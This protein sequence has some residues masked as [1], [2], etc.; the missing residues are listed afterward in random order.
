MDFA[1][2]MVFQSQGDNQQQGPR[3]EYVHYQQN[4]FQSIMESI[5]IGNSS[6]RCVVI[7]GLHGYRQTRI[8]QVSATTPHSS[9]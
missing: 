6:T 2:G 1:W 3:T 5:Q 8:W 4:V 9:K 7:L